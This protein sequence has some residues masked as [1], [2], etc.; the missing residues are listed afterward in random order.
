M[1]H[2]CKGMFFRFAF[3]LCDMLL[4]GFNSVAKG[5]QIGRGEGW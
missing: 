3:E 5:C 1:N 4:N 2:L